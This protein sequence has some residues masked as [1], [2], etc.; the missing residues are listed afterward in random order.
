[1]AIKGLAALALL[2][3]IH[4]HQPASPDQPPN[5]TTWICTSSGGCV[6]QDTSIVL[7]WES[8]VIH[9]TDSP[10]PCLSTNVINSTICPDPVTCAQ[11]CVVEAANYTHSGVSTA[12]DTLT[13]QQYVHENG[14]PQPASPRVFLLGPDF[15]YLE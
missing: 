13:L 11:N 4:G 14:Q 10:T 12:G 9:E 1:M 7:E 5:L 2:S 8:R 15:Q 6:A 3:A